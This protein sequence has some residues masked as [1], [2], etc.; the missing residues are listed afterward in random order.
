MMRKIRKALSSR[1]MRNKVL[2]IASLLAT[3]PVL[4]MGMTAYFIASKNIIQDIGAANQETMLQI[5]QRIDEKL[6]TLENMTLQNATNPTFA[7]FLSLSKPGEDI[8]ALGMTMTIL[9]SM[10][11]LIDDVNSVYLYRPDQQLVVSPDFGMRSDQVLPAYIKEAVSLSPSKIWLDHRLE[12]YT[13]RDGL[14]QITLIRKIDTPDNSSGGYLIVNLDET[15]LFRIFNNMNLGEN[16][17]LLIITPRYNIFSDQSQHLLKR[18]LQEYSFLGSMMDPSSPTNTST[19]QIDGLKMSLN[20]IES[21]YNGW[22][23]VTIVPY[24]DVTQHLQKIQQATLMICLLLV[25]VSALASGVLSKRW[26]HAFQ[27][28]IEVVKKKSGGADGRA[29][30]NEFTLI[31][32]YFESLEH[33]NDR[34]EK[35]IEDSMPTL[36]SNFIHR[37][38]NEPFRPDMIEQAAYYD[39]PDRHPYYTVV[40]IELDNMRG[41]TEQD[42][43]LFHYAVLNI[44]KEVVHHHAEGMVVQMHSGHI[45][46]LLNHN[47]QKRTLDPNTGVFHIAEEIRSIA[48]SLLH[49][50]VTLGVGHSYEGLGQVKRSFREAMESLDYQLIQGS[51]KVLY[52]GQIKLEGSSMHYPYEYEQQIITSLKLGNLGKIQDL[53][54]SFAHALKSEAVDYDQVRQSFTQ[55]LAVSQR[56]ML[57]LDANSPQIHGSKLYQR[58]FELNTT[59]KI[60]HWFKTEIYPPMTEHIQSRLEQRTHSTIQQALD[61]IQEHYDSDLS[62]PIVADYIAMPV[63]H[64]SHV[65]KLEV[66]MTFSEYLIAYRME[67][68]RELLETTNDK[69]SD[70]AEKLR[71]NN[72]QN[73]I[74]VFKKMNSA[75]PGEYRTRFHKERLETKSGS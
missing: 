38:L 60:V 34:L 61:Y 40:C 52:I 33:N 6:S 5:Q 29:E 14:H 70:I 37:L 72:S 67:K 58:L 66:G 20:Y 41:H 64:F 56:T 71:Y 3:I 24:S 10:Q 46:M 21:P 45:V 15:T 47:E 39:V 49:I 25:V 68:A 19:V 1:L 62:M 17:E 48:E 75:T 74:R 4:I 55:L 53:L 27:S 7:H 8:E 42:T 65:F 69:I 22:K 50:T 54:D 63:S 28:L 73:F 36:R 26:L 31:R 59:E 9:S 51:G 18:P 12:S 30:E 11:V 57:E 32:S 16:R 35:Q 13:Y 44:V 23:Y 2:I 43:N